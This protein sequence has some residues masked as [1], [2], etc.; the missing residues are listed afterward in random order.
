ME[1]KIMKLAYLNAPDKKD[2]HKHR[3][4]TLIEVM[5]VVAILAIISAIALPSYNEQVK[6]G[7]RSDGK[8]F[9]LDLSSRQQRF[10]SRNVA[11]AHS[12]TEKTGLNLAAA[13]SPEGHYS[14]AI[15]ATPKGCSSGGERCTAFDLVATPQF[16]DPSCATLTYDSRGIKGFTGTA[17]SVDECWR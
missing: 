15:T 13:T 5:I 7:K 9:L 12:L 3:G 11:F 6:R 16:A 1:M 8:A 10:H 17:T 2:M 4:F 14:V